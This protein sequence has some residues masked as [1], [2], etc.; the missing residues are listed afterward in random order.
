M[1]A[2]LLLGLAS[3]YYDRPKWPEWTIPRMVIRSLADLSEKYLG[4]KLAKDPDVRLHFDNYCKDGSIADLP[5]EFVQ[6]VKNDAMVTG[7]VWE[8]MLPHLGKK[9]LSE[10]LQTAASYCTSRMDERGVCVDTVE[11]KRLREEFARD[12]PMLQDGLARHGLGSW[13]PVPG[14]VKRTLAMSIP[15][16][17][18]WQADVP[19]CRKVYRR[20]QFK[21]A[22][23]F[24]EADAVF[25][26]STK[27]VRGAL[28]RY[29]DRLP[30]PP[31]RTE[32]TDQLALDSDW[33]AEHIPS[34]DQALQIWLKHEKLRKILST[35]LDLYV[36]TPIVF[37][38]W[39]VLGARSGRMSCASPNVQNIPKRKHGIRSLFVPSPG[40]VFVK[41]DY[42]TQELLTLAE[43]MAGLGLRGPLFDGIAAG[44]DLHRWTAGLLLGKSPDAVSGLERQSAK[45]VNF[46]VPGGLGAKKLAAYAAQNYNVTWSLAEAKEMR[47]SFLTAF[48]D[49]ASY[50]TL[51]STSMHNN[52]MRVTGR[53]VGYWAHELGCSSHPLELKK[54]FKG[55]TNQAIR[56]IFYEAERSL[57]VTLPTGRVRHACLFTE[58]ANTYFQGLASDV[59]KRAMLLCELNGLKTVLVVHDEI[60]VECE[61]EVWESRR[62]LLE[63]CMRDAF[64]DVCPIVGGYAK[65]ESDGPLSSWGPATDKTGGVV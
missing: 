22:S 18:R 49:I 8:K 21:K 11:A 63:Y 29:V 33:W 6:Y 41:C 44:H 59:T 62:A 16:A 20:K 39:N 36:E 32:K 19:E 35:Y 27:A 5:L 56:R 2:D 53:G 10:P 28:E 58:G 48:P 52:L 3:G 37:P 17:G 54:A 15:P 47:K 26:L 42:S 45:A 57:T 12:L 46:G 9:L 61:P 55:S 25:K 65:V 51:M 34:E 24:E 30:E 43:A 13:H 23:V 31:P 38:R 50:L 64:I 7:R 14:T 1:Y 4:V 60:V 40:Q